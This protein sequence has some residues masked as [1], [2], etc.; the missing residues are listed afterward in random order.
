MGEWRRELLAELAE[1]PDTLRRVRTGA[2]NFELVSRRLAASSESLEQITAL[3]EST[4]ADTTRRSA[5]AAEALRKQIDSLVGQSPERV[6][7]TLAEMQR[8]IE[9][10]AQLNPLWPTARRPPSK[11]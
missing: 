5:D 6:T 1:L 10:L 8:T 11:G 2:G 3:Y 7:S 9:A 4:L